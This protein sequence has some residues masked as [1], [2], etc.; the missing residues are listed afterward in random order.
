MDY[1][2]DVIEAA[3]LSWNILSKT[4]D[5]QPKL[6]DDFKE[7]SDFYKEMVKNLLEEAQEQ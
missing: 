3:R 2:K 4:V 5:K 7:F 6:F 1:N